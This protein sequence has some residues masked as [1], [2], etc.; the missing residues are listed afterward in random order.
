M[1][2]DLL[3]KQTKKNIYKGKLNTILNS[4]NEIDFLILGGM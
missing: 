1:H 3:K 2:Q 4:D